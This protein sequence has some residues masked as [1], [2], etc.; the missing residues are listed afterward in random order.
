MAAKPRQRSNLS[1]NR[2]RSVPRRPT[3]RPA[4]HDDTLRLNF[5]AGIAGNSRRLVS[6]P[7]ASRMATSCAPTPLPYIP[8]TN[9]NDSANSTNRR[10]RRRAFRQPHR[11]CL[12]ASDRRVVQRIGSPRWHARSRLPHPSTDLR[13]RLRV[14]YFRSGPLHRFPSVGLQRVRGH[15]GKH[16]VGRRWRPTLL[17]GTPPPPRQAVQPKRGRLAHHALRRLRSEVRVPLQ[18]RLELGSEHISPTHEHDAM[19]GT[20]CA[21]A[22]DAVLDRRRETLR[23]VRQPRPCSLLARSGQLTR[24]APAPA[25]TL[26]IRGDQSGRAGAGAR[27]PQF[28]RFAGR[29]GCRKSDS[30][31]GSCW[32]WPPP[33][34]LDVIAA[35][36]ARGRRTC[37][38]AGTARSWRGR[39]FRPEDGVSPPT[40]NSRS[41]ESG[42]PTS[43]SC[44]GERGRT[45]SASDPSGRRT[46]R[47]IAH[48][49]TPTGSPLRLATK[50]API[51]LRSPTLPASTRMTRSPRRVGGASA[52]CS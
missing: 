21:G 52:E 7:L 45:G 6:A 38:K 23:R 13:L 16:G 44:T 5:L 15:V 18:L 32:Q 36:P 2:A 24:G 48:G 9:Q 30:Y 43:S 41:R 1:P 34:P 37:A 12:R 4:P 20:R 29:R 40:I 46:W 27:D 31:R 51:R 25:R 14:G 28:I 42:S 49:R 22:A 26:G 19:H 3:V 11:G 8:R 50:P 47:P 17:R 35:G 39:S 33:G 10:L